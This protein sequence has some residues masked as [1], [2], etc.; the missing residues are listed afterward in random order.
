MK[1]I[2]YTFLVLVGIGVVVNYWPVIL[3][4]LILVGIFGGSGR[5]C[6]VTVTHRCG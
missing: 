6:K 2:F 1:Y 3:G 4:L 5:G